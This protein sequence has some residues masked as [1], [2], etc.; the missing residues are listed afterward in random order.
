[1]F[2]QRI[3]LFKV[4]LA[5]NV[6][7]VAIT[8]VVAFATASYVDEAVHRLALAEGLADVALGFLQRN[9]CSDNQLDVEVLRVS[10]LFVVHG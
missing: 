5:F 3:G 4:F 6:N 7:V 8:E 1:M 9:L 10:Y 2:E